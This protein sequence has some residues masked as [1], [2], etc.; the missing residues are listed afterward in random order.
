MKVLL[1]TDIPHCE[2]FTAGLV[3]NQLC[4]FLPPDSICFYV[5]AN[6]ALPLKVSD[7]FGAVPRV[8]RAKPNENWSWLPAGKLS[9]YFSGI[10]VFAAEKWISERRVNRLIRDCVDFARAQEVDRVWV[11]LQGQTM[12]RMAGQVASEL[13][14]P[15]YTQVWDPFSWW[16]RAHRLDSRTTYRMLEMTCSPNCPRL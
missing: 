5:V 15:L 7:N 13:E 3:L 2:D 14:L 4:Q 9:K 8:I 11:V 16:A 1:L 10:F 6:P 12:I